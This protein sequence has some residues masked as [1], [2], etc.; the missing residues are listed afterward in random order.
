M[1]RSPA[2]SGSSLSTALEYDASRSTTSRDLVTHISRT[3]SGES[4]EGSVRQ[5]RIA[6]LA[7]QRRVSSR[8]LPRVLSDPALKLRQDDAIIAVGVRHS[9]PA[10]HTPCRCTPAKIAGNGVGATPHTV[11]SQPFA[12]P[13]HTN[14]HLHRHRFHKLVRRHLVQDAHFR[15]HARDGAQQH[16]HVT[17]PTQKPDA[18]RSR[19]KR[20][21]EGTHAPHALRRAH[22]HSP[23]IVRR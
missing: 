17:L 22:C 11:P 7:L 5:A 2:S 1:P 12:T 16:Y 21:E 23:A 8:H 14:V 20:R 13:R 4:G 18:K 19:E 15:Q 6:A 9:K 10:H 3:D